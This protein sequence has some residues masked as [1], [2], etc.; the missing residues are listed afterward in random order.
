MIPGSNSKQTSMEGEMPNPHFDM[1]K[2]FDQMGFTPAERFI[3]QLWCDTERRDRT[4]EEMVGVLAKSL[5]RFE[6]Y[7]ES[8]GDL[9]G[10]IVLRQRV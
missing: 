4:P 1:T 2:F 9:K 8:K 7:Y 6:V 3:F 5:P 10:E